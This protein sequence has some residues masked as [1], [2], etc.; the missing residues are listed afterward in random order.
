MAPVEAKKNDAP[1]KG[2][3]GKKSKKHP[4]NSYLKGGILR[5]SKS[6]VSIM[7]LKLNNAYIVSET[8]SFQFCH[9]CQISPVI[10]VVI[11]Y[12]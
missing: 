10:N 7:A 8:F 3:A 1:S 11:L 9:N 2:K 12:F 6:Q 4:L 5:Y